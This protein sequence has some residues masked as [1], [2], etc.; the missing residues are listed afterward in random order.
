[1]ELLPSIVIF[2]VVALCLVGAFSLIS[3]IY[4]RLK[5]RRS[6]LAEEFSPNDNINEPYLEMTPLNI[7]RPKDALFKEE[8]LPKNSLRNINLSNIKNSKN[9]SFSISVPQFNNSKTLHTT[10]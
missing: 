2:I 6:L 8:M 9:T 7:H 4:F 3:F 1:M 10:A 5:K